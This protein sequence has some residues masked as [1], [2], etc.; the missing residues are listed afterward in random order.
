MDQ[1]DKYIEKIVSKKITEPE[2]LEDMMLSAI[3]TEKGKRKI[4]RNRITRA[5]LTS[6]TTIFITTGVGGAGYIAYEKI[7]KN[8]ERYTYEE[9]QNTLANVDNVDDIQ[10][11]ITEEEAKEKATTIMN[12]LGYTNETI[13]SIVLEKDINNNNEPFYNI[14]TSDNTEEGIIIK[15]SANDGDILSF[16]NN[17]FLNVE[18]SKNDINGDKAKEYS[19][20][21]IQ[22]IGFTENEYQF[23]QCTQQQMIYNGQTKNVWVANYC[24]TYDGIYNPYEV[25]TTNFIISDNKVEVDKIFEIKDGTYDNNPTVITEDEAI[26]VA[27]NKEKELTSK[28]I[29][30]VS[31]EVGIR[32]MNSYIYALENNLQ[33]SNDE[34]ENEGTLDIDDKKIR[35]IWM[36]KITHKNTN[37]NIDNLDANQRLKNANKIYYI[38]ITTAEILGGE[39]IMEGGI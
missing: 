13:K 15:L 17:N 30:T 33:F 29:E 27:V 12:N 7:W 20:K 22:D 16:T 19:D 10:K 11:A 3:H 9:I 14:M 31:T 34:F 36:V 24:K 25:L 6:L 21:I 32:K 1:L 4:K 37:E 18:T 39:E 5:I 38:D 2:N 35:K 28:E 8:P 26:Q 23:T